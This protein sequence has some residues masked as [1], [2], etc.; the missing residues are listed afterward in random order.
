MTDSEIRDAILDGLA[1]IA[2]EADLASLDPK[3]NLRAALDLDSFDFLR[4][5]IELGEATGVEVPEADYGCV[6]TLETMSE[7]IT[8]AARGRGQR[9]RD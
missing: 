6:T 4:F 9:G 3:A 8:K 7:Y 1:R 5:L 2:P